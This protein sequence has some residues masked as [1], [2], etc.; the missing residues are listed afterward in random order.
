MNRVLIQLF[1]ADDPF[2][3][4]SLDALQYLLTSAR[5]LLAQVSSMQEKSLEFILPLAY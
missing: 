1:E 5:E 4:L 2:T 3:L